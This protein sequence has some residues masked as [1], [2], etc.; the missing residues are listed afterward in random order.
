M[1]DVIETTCEDLFKHALDDCPSCDD[2]DDDGCIV[3]ATIKKNYTVD[4][5]IDDDMIDNFTD[6]HLLPSTDLITDVVR[7]MLENGG[8]KGRR[9]EEGPQGKSGAGIEDV[10]ADFVE[11]NQPG[12]AWIGEEN[13]KRTLFLEIPRGRDA[14]EPERPEYTRICGI[15]WVHRGERRKDAVEDQGIVIAFNHPIR[16][17][18]I[19]RH[20]FEV[21]SHRIEDGLICW[22]EL[23][24]HAHGVKLD[25]EPEEEGTFRI[26]GVQ[27]PHVH[28]TYETLVNGA[29]F[30]ADELSF[31]PG[32]LRVI[33]KGDLI[34]DER[35]RGIDANH[36]PP[37]LPERVTGDGVEGGTFESW[38]T[39]ETR[40]TRETRETE[41]AEEKEEKKQQPARATQRRSQVRR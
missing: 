25:L 39:V 28:P 2:D 9:G 33:L 23:P 40:E 17:I 32:T 13:E 7:C 38:F 12:R 14:R 41:E 16:A 34:R 6:R 5:K 36:L 8:G 20:T 37:W 31:D 3:L 19:N 24:G 35:G 4:A 10:D 27:E 11:A 29:I 1:I 18:D 22:C 21:L 15:N 30:R 26:V